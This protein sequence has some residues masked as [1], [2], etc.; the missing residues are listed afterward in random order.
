MTLHKWIEAHG[1]KGEL[2]LTTVDPWMHSVASE[3]EGLL[4]QFMTNAVDH[5]VTDLAVLKEM[6][7][8]RRNRG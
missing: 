1:F 2:V 7:D 4:N 3:N 8:E 5:L 6:A